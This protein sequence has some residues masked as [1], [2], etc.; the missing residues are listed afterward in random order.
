MATDAPVTQVLFDMDGLLLDTESIY[1]DVTQSIVG[2]YGKV[3]DWSVKGNMIGRGSRESSQ[4]LVDTLALPITADDYL[5]ERDVL[6]REAFP[7]AG[8][9]PGA[10]AL[11]RHL[12]ARDIPIA[13]ATSSDRDLFELKIRRHGEWFALFDAVVTGDHPDV[14]SAKPAPD[15]FLVAAAALGGDPANTLVFEDAPSGLQAGLT[16]GMRV[17]A[18]PDPNMDK[19]RYAGAVEIIDSLK[20]FDPARYGL[21]AM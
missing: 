16:A 6:L 20:Q 2:R 13:V 10:E 19:A 21:P 11:V 9:L 17:V 3:F 15:I 12:A 5:R 8:A 7:R 4:Y 18:V 1:T 14:T